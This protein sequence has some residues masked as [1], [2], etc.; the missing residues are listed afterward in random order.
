MASW[1][2]RCHALLFPG[3]EATPETMKKPVSGAAAFAQDLRTY[4]NGTHAWTSDLWDFLIASLVPVVCVLSLGHSCC[5]G[6]LCSAAHSP[7][8]NT[9]A[10]LCY[11]LKPFGNLHVPI[12]L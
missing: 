11:L 1:I 5:I 6:L 8:S 10:I 4:R 12:A 2:P 7:S 9:V 3:I